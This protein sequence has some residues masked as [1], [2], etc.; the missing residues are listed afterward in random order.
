MITN[1][2]L[3]GNA[4]MTSNNARQYG[5]D[6]KSKKWGYG[7]KGPGGFTIPKSTTEQA[8]D[9]SALAKKQMSTGDYTNATPY[10]VVNDILTK[11]T[12]AIPEGLKDIGKTSTNTQT[13]EQTVAAPVQ[14]AAD[15]TANYM[16]DL[17]GAAKPVAQA[18]ITSTAGD[19][20]QDFIKTLMKGGGAGT[21][22]MAGAV[23]P[24]DTSFM[25]EGKAAIKAQTLGDMDMSKYVNPAEGALQASILHGGEVQNNAIRARMAKGGAFGGNMAVAQGQQNENTMRQLGLAAR[26]AYQLASQNA[27]GDVDRLNATAA[28]NRAAVQGVNSQKLGANLTDAQRALSGGQAINQGEAQAGNDAWQM[29]LQKIG[30]ATGVGSTAAGALGSLPG[31]KTTTQTGLAPNEAAAGLGT[32]IGLTGLKAEYDPNKPKTA[33][34]GGTVVSSSRKI[35]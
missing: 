33:A 3:G 23:K 5:Y 21:A 2:S 17:V 12:A 32:L 14:A 26:D 34:G 25:D 24:T 16:G 20:A 18:A 30:M 29:Y 4:G 1:H 8:A 19:E 15:Q 11:G 31:A 9:K 6:F 10:D 28:G 35:S 13:Q 27:G 22:A 7:V